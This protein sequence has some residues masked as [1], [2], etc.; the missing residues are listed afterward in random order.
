LLPP[1]DVTLAYRVALSSAQ[2]VPL[3]ALPLSGRSV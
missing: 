1:I 2:F 3:A